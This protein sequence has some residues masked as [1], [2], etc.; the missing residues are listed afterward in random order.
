[1]LAPRIRSPVPP[2]VLK[3]SALLHLRIFVVNLHARMTL[4]LVSS[5]LPVED[6]L[7][8]DAFG[9]LLDYLDLW[10][11]NLCPR[12]DKLLNGDSRR[13]L[14]PQF[15]HSLVFNFIKC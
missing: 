2:Q 13:S 6:E 7:G 10:V 5:C 12:L 14:G 4:C 9:L 1:M 3:E 11:W 15:D 8:R